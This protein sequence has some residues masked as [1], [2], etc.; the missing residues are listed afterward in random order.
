MLEVK[1]LSALEMEV[2]PGAVEIYQNKE[3]YRNHIS[4]L[5]MVVGQYNTIMRTI[6]DV[7]RPL[8]QDRITI[9]DRILEEVNFPF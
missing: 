7:E 3:E 8:V 5:Q 1:Y 9:I 6:L 2:P 4:N